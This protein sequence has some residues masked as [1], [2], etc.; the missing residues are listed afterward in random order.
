MQTQKNLLGGVFGIGLA[1]LL[2]Q[3]NAVTLLPHRAVYDISL[4]K[5]EG[6][7][8]ISNATGRM[9]FELLGSS[10]EGYTVNYRFV[11]R[12]VDGDGNSV[13]TDFRVT[14]YENT[15]A[16]SFNFASSNFINN[17]QVEETRGHA[18]RKGAGISVKLS[19]PNEQTIDFPGAVSF[20]T[21]Q[22]EEILDAAQAG[23]KIMQHLVYDGS[24]QGKKLFDATSIIGS[25]GILPKNQQKGLLKRPEFADTTY[26]P[27]TISYFDLGTNGEALP[28][29]VTSFDVHENGISRKITMDYG[30]MALSAKLTDLE[31]LNV[32]ICD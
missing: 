32:S 12:I 8:A 15:E 2:G 4:I 18:Q 10:C 28:N 23:K 21:Q 17:K 7:S 9:V 31:M 20:P 5:N 1:C 26:W 19:K 6:G 25:G 14:S 13:V 30:D 24:E 27:I 11:T 29:Y 16:Q 3:A 22:F